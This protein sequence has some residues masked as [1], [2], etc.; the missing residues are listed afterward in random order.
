M[1]AYSHMLYSLLTEPSTISEEAPNGS[2]IGSKAIG[3]SK[4]V[5]P[6]PILKSKVISAVPAG[7]I[8]TKSQSSATDYQSRVT[9]GSSAEAPTI[10]RGDINETLKQMTI[11]NNQK[12]SKSRE[13]SDASTSTHGLPL[14]SYVP[15]SWML[16]EKKEDQKRL[17][18]LIVVR[19]SSKILVSGLIRILYDLLVLLLEC[20]LMLPV[21]T[22][23]E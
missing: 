12:N 22:F 10:E 20:G 2:K 4:L 23:S 15:E 16:K 5:T 17:L 1:H 8:K 14:E 19:N 21:H 9:N 7:S 13:V 6:A 11:N 3:A 18:H